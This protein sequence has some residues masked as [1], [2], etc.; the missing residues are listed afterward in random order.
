MRT[1]FK[2]MVQ[3][4]AVVLML[5][6]GLLAGGCGTA[7]PTGAAQAPSQGLEKLRIALVPAEEA[8]EQV[9]QYSKAFRFLEKKLGMQVEPFL[10]TDYTGV[11]EAMRAKHLD[12]AWYGPFSYILAAQEA[13]AEAFALPIGEKTGKTYYSYII[14]RADTGIG[15]LEDLKG[16]TFT[17]GDPASTS[18]HLIPRYTL[19]KAGINP[20]KDFKS[21]QFS[22]AHDATGL[23]VA[24]GKVDA[25]AI[26][27][28]AYQ[29]LVE[30]KLVDE[31]KMRTIVKSDP[32]PESPWAMRKDLPADLKGR[33]KDALMAMPQEEP[34]ALKGTGYF[35]FEQVSD[36]DYDMIRETAKALK[37]D[38]KKMK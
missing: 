29:R 22:G 2:G 8:A 13:G 12:V 26:W 38:I 15:K 4:S 30:K 24:N 28:A 11:I 35:K 19:V 1:R 33:I 3:V 25:G 5:T 37:L 32:I 14:T 6:L 17:F 10:A 20:D 9:K 34:E 36:G 16:R 31:S 7:A 18:G 21:V 27:D 23:A